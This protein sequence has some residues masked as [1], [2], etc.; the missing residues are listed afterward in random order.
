[1]KGQ[2]LL[3]CERTRKN[4]T[5]FWGGGGA[6]K[7]Y[8]S[9]RFILNE[10]Y[11]LQT[12]I[13]LRTRGDDLMNSWKQVL[14]PIKMGNFVVTLKAP[15]NFDLETGDF[16]EVELA[17][18]K[19]TCIN[20]NDTL[21]TE[22]ASIPL[23]QIPAKV[24]RGANRYLNT[25]GSYFCDSIAVKREVNSGEEK[26]NFVRKTYGFNRSGNQYGR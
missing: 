26:P 1:L 17:V 25:D 2:R 24:W 23:W 4:I 6:N 21:Q 22:I 3:K 10:D 20:P 5:A 16:S 9:A 8:A 19:I 7:I 18:R 13:F 11:G 15:R 12:G 14:T